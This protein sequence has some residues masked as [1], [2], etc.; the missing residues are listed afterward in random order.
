MKKFLIIGGECISLMRFRGELLKSIKKNKYEVYASAGGNCDQVKNWFKDEGINFI[1][2]QLNRTGINPIYDLN[3]IFQLVHMIRKINPDII[4]AYTVKPVV[5]GLIASKI[6]KVK[7]CY[8]LI[9]G[10]GYA[11]IPSISLKKRVIKIII[12]LL[13]KFSLL[14]AKTIFFQNKDDLKLFKEKK[15]ISNS[16]HAIVINGSGVN[17]DHYKF[18]PFPAN[19][20]KINFLLIAR[21]LKDKGIYEYVEAAKIIKKSYPYREVRFSLLGSLDTNPSAITYDEIKAWTNKGLIHFIG[22][23]DDVRPFIE[24]C[25]VYV[26]PSYREGMPRSVLE[27]MSIGRPIITTNVPGCKETV[28]PGKNGYLVEMK[29]SDELAL[30]MSKFINNDKQLQKM[31]LYS[32]K[33]VAER[34]NVYNVN[35]IIL[36]EIGIIPKEI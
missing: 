31:G 20:K 8:A 21:L 36:K 12:I 25:S 11:F 14:K 24:Q 1:P 10:L 23:T 3:Y 16:K 2:L 7:Y 27:A 17:L 33:L 15:I 34:F 4:L 35:D 5:Y 32:R 6:C 30:A 19:T 18:K 13:Y 22:E 26:L 28:I 9:T 29:S